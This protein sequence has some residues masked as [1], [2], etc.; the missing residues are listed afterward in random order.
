MAGNSFSIQNGFE[1]TKKVLKLKNPP[2]AIFAM[3][4]L[5]GF[6]VLMAVKELGLKIP[7]AVSL[8]IF[9]N[10]PYLSILNPSISIVKQDS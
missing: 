3:N 2:T 5:I 9:D 8:I 1:S 6:G 10:H 4:N 7:Q